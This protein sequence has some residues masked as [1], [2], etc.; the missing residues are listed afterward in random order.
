MKE[1]KLMKGNEVVA[2]AAIQAV[3]FLRGISDYPPE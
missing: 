2:K 3:P 1:R